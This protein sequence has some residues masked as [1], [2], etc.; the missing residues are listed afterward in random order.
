MSDS[1]ARLVEALRAPSF[2]QDS[3][4]HDARAVYAT[5]PRALLEAAAD[6]I[7]ALEADLAARGEFIEAEREMRETAEA[8]LKL[9]LNGCKAAWPIVY[10]C[11]SKEHNIET[12]GLRGRLAALDAA[13][14][15]STSG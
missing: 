12:W 1:V 9:A 14:A 6:R 5:K 13:L 3:Q 8:A 4:W 15:Q 2:E 7:V 11:I 10:S